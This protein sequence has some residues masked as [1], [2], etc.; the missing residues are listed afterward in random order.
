MPTTWC[1]RRSRAAHDSRQPRPNQD[2]RETNE[3]R[4]DGSREERESEREK[5]GDTVGG[6]GEA[7][8]SKDVEGGENNHCTRTNGNR[9]QNNETTTAR[10]PERQELYMERGESD[11]GLP[12]DGRETNNGGREQHART[13]LQMYLFTT[14]VPWHTTRNTRHTPQALHSLIVNSSVHGD[15]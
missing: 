12:T 1:L 9:G 3:T 13:V 2:G 8:S 4:G 10:P 14:P 7:L 5:D 11:Q 6:L 15:G